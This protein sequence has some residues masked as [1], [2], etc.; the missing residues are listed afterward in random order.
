MLRAALFTL[1]AASVLGGGAQAQHAGSGFHG[2]P[3]ARPG[4]PG[5]GGR[6][7]LQNRSFAGRRSQRGGYYDGSIFYPGFAT[8]DEGSGYDQPDAEAQ[9]NGR[10]PPVAT[11]QRPEPPVPKSQ[12]IEIPRVAGSAVAK[13]PPPTIF[14]LAS[15]ERLETRRF[16]LTANL[17]TV[18]IDRQRRTVPVDKLDINATLSSNRD[19]GIDLRIPDDR[20]EIS[21]SF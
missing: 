10:E 19:R 6:R 5:I 8:Y 17:L 11:L 12:V 4:H 1:L 3:G 16:V 14:V 15:G 9:T 21:V 7:G 20:N 2:G 13:E 18:N